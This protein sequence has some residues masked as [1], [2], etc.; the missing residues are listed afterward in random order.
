MNASYFGTTVVWGIALPSWI[1]KGHFNR[2][3]LTAHMVEH[4]RGIMS[5]YDKGP[6]KMESMVLVNGAARSKASTDLG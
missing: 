5:H 4:I 2:S 1:S 3:Q 6:L